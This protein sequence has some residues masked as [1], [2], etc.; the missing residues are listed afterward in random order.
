MLARVP[1]TP[2]VACPTSCGSSTCLCHAS[3]AAAPP[4]S[5]PPQPPPCLLPALHAQWCGHCKALVPEYERAAGALK[6]ILAVG[7]VNA[8]EH[9]QLGAEL[10][11]QGY[12]TIK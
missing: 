10:Q 2:R 8:D 5:Q 6:G 4:H 1:A 11:V 7:A 9:K 3:A 12:P